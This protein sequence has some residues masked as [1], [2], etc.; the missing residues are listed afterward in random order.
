MPRTLALEDATPEAIAPYGALIGAGLGAGRGTGFYDDAVMLYDTPRFASDADTC[1]SVA[2]VSRRAGEV[3]FL[4]RHFKHTQAFLP[5]N[6]APYAVVVAP[7]TPSCD[8]PELA[9]VRAFRFRGDR[10]FMMHVGTWHEFPFALVDPVDLVIVLRNETN[11]DLQA[12]ANGE[13]A[14]EDL[15]KRNVE[16]RF[17]A[18]LRV[19]LD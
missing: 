1:L 13:A 17:G 15:Q 12:V 5:L 4:E 9:A 14:G 19:L 2:R 3:R 8:V 18:V 10:G 16:Q 11:R 7:P 6:G